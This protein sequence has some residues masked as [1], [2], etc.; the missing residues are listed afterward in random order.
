MSIARPAADIDAVAL[1]I[2]FDAA[3]LGD[4]RVS[5]HVDVA[6]DGALDAQRAITADAAGHAR[7]CADNADF[8]W[9]TG[10]RRI[11]GKLVRQAPVG[12]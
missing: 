10:H 3:A 7:G 8:T 1:Q 4:L 11:L 5:V 9:V 12:N 2:A 6:F